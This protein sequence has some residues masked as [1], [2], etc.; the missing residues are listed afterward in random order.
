[1]ERTL[2][3]GAA[4]FLGRHLIAS[5][6][7]AGTP[8]VA[9]CRD[10]GALAAL[11]HPLLQV[12][13]ADVRDAEACARLLDGVDTVFHL[14]AVRNLPGASPEEMTAVNETATV[15]LARQAASAGARRFVAVGT[16]QAYGSSAQPLAESAPLVPDRAGSFYAATKARATLALRALAAEGAAVV[17]LL[18]TIVYGPDHPSRPNR[19]TDHVRRLLRR[20]VDVAVGGGAEPRDLVH[21]EDVVAALLAAAREPAALGEELLLTGEP[22]TYRGLTR[23]VA[24]AAGRRP[25]LVLSLPLPLARLAARLVDGVRGFDRRCGWASAVET[26]ARPWSFCGDRARRLLGWRP[27]PLAQGVAETVAWIRGATR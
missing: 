23:L 3:T 5:L 7:A 24:A 2:V 19:V 11:A 4:G 10:P 12:A 13:R 20:S 22:V 21:V 25:P 17:T 9:L 27:R 15:R 6:V 16:A 8:A 26:L 1:V 14:A 18:P